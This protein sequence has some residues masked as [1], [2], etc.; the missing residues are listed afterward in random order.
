LLI[1]P[2]R[3][4]WAPSARPWLLRH[5][6]QYA[7]TR[8]QFA[9]KPSLR[10]VVQESSPDDTKSSKR[11]SSPFNVGSA[12]KDAGKVDPAHISMLKMN[13]VAIALDIA[14]KSRDVLGAKRLVDDFCIMRHMNNLES[15]FTYEGTNDIHKLVIGEKS[16]HP[17]SS[18]DGVSRSLF[19]AFVGRFLK[20]G[21]LYSVVQVLDIIQSRAI[22]IS[23]TRWRSLCLSILP[24]P[25][26]TGFFELLSTP[27]ASGNLVDP[28]QLILTAVC[29]IGSSAPGPISVRAPI[30]TLFPMAASPHSRTSATSALI[31]S[32]FLS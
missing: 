23:A 22:L 15:V 3:H 26:R 4:W 12:S 19:F 6:L 8:K 5:P 29:A 17:P 16:R 9:N 28:L 2:L 25:Q 32:T 11:S 7:K 21:A 30:S 10:T 24:T 31:L 14:R 18:K 1:K 13:N 27:P 20:R